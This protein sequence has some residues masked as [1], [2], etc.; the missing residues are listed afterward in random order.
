MTTNA[1]VRTAWAENVFANINSGANSFSRV[2]EPVSQDEI[3]LCYDANTKKIYGWFY[4]VT[5]HEEHND[6]GGGINVRDQIFSVALTHMRE[7]GEGGTDLAH[8]EVIDAFETLTGLV[9]TNLT[10][11]WDSTVDY[12]EKPSELEVS[13]GTW[14]GKPIWIGKQVFKARKKVSS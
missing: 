5:C 7:K 13:S 9:R 6:I 8:N 11:N 12:W 3:A 1:L 10:I 4:V 2:I 14:D